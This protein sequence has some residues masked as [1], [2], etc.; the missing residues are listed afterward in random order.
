MAE[1]KELK[2]TINIAPLNNYYL[3]CLRVLSLLFNIFISALFLILNNVE[4]ASYAD[5]DTPYCSNQNFA[6][7]IACLERTA[8]NLFAWFNSNGMKANA[9]KS[10]KEKTKSK[11]IK[12][13]NHE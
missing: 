10:H 9:E 6:D 2:V 13:Y 5:D 4:S 12:L 11:H 8:D 7:V 1:N 3:E